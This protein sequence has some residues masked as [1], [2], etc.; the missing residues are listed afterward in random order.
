MNKGDIF[1]GFDAD[2]ENLKL[3]KIRLDEANKTKKAKIFLINSN[4]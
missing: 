4:F 1:I 2:I 3:A